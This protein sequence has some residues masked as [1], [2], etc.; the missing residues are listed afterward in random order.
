MMTH[1][2]M[3]STYSHSP[4]DSRQW[5]FTGMEVAMWLLRRFR[6]AETLARKSTGYDD[7]D[8]VVGIVEDVE[9]QQR[10]DHW[11]IHLF[12]VFV[13]LLLHF[14]ILPLIGM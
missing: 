2:R 1:D 6:Q 3:S 5:H 12:W 9:L 11:P 14:E 4:M 8:N 10:P 7:D 13:L